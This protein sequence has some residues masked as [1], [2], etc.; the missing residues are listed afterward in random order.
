[1]S[2]KDVLFLKWIFE[3]HFDRESYSRRSH[4][5]NLMKSWLLNVHILAHITITFIFLYRDYI[6]EFRS[7]IFMHM[8][9]F[10]MECGQAGWLFREIY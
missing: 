4:N 8:C 3:E 1:M 10:L 6:Y 7:Y 5:F 2:L 9:I